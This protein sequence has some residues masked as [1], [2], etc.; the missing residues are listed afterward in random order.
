MVDEYFSALHAGSHTVILFDRQ[1]RFRI[2]TVIQFGR[3]K[4]NARFRR[5]PHPS[6]RASR[7]LVLM[8]TDSKV[9][10][11]HIFKKASESKVQQNCRIGE[12]ICT[13]HSD[14]WDQMSRLTCHDL[15]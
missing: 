1:E 6:E 4:A 14:N 13:F 12:E 11:K 8:S 15:E 5:F 7:V 2:Y 10:A 3:T 9:R